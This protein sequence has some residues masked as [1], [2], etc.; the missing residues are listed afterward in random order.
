[1]ACS[2]RERPRSGLECEARS[3]LRGTGRPPRVWIGLAVRGVGLS[4][5]GQGCRRPGTASQ[6]RPLNFETPVDPSFSP[7]R[8]ASGRRGH[9]ARAPRAARPSWLQEREPLRLA[10]FHLQR[11]KLTASPAL[12]GPTS[13]ATVKSR[14][15]TNA[16]TSAMYAGGRRWPRWVFEHHLLVWLSWPLAAGSVRPSGVLNVLRELVSQRSGMD[17]LAPSGGGDGGQPA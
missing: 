8:L 15:A 4:M 12:P 17:R 5:A 13:M 6:Q 16:I 11:G 2:D 14:V 7:S 9:A 10:T 3:D 1:L